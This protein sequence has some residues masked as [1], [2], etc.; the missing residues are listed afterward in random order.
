MRL[1]LFQI[2][3]PVGKAG[4]NSGKQQCPGEPVV[5]RLPLIRGLK[6]VVVMNAGGFRGLSES[7]FV[8]RSTLS[9]QFSRRQKEPLRGPACSAGAL[10]GKEGNIA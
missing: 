10:L 1:H 7:A 5:T 9:N 2:Q 6:V 4:E 3:Y 8:A